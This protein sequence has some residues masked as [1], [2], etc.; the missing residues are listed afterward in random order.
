MPLHFVI[1]KKKH[2]LNLNKYRNN[3]FQLNNKLKAMYSDLA[4]AKMF[5]YKNKNHSKIELTFTYYK[6]TKAIRDRANIL[7]IHEKYFCDALTRMRFIPDDNDMYIQSSHYYSGGV[8]RD[9][10]RVEILIKIL[11]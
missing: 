5:R 11:Q 9:N 8:D 1:C 2:H 6:P 7:S 3:H 4:C 10:P